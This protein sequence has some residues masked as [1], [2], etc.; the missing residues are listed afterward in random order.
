MREEFHKREY[1]PVLGWNLGWLRNLGPGYFDSPEGV[2][3]H[4]KIISLMKYATYL[5]SFSSLFRF[6]FAFW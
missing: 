6:S 1:N 2:N 3:C 4:E 5:S